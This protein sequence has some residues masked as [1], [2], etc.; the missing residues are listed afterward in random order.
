MFEGCGGHGDGKRF[1]GGEKG[2]LELQPKRRVVVGAVLRAESDV[3]TDGSLRARITK[4]VIEIR[5]DDARW[6][7]DGFDQPTLPTA[8]DL[9]FVDGC[10]NTKSHS[11]VVDLCCG[12]SKTRRL[13]C[14]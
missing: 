14:L 1:V 8:V 2:R 5:N 13:G 4:P 6:A 9:G 7:P 3:G 12:K 11:A 10:S